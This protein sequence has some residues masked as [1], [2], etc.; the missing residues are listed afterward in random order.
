MNI[1]QSVRMYITKMC[2]ES[3]PGMKLLLMDKETVS[4]AVVWDYHRRYSSLNFFQTS[5]VS[6][7]FSQSEILQKEVFLFERI[8]VASQQDQMKHLKCIVF[9]RPTGENIAYLA[10]ELQ[11]PKYGVYYLCKLLQIIFLYERFK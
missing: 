10:H 6:M 3:G 11:E 9:L 2:D 7:A 1:V 4:F 5:I 8:D